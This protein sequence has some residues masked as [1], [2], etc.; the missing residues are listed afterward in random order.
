[1]GVESALNVGTSESGSFRERREK[2]FGALVAEARAL[3]D[4][5]RRGATD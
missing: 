1:M 5:L 2:E 3:H 4:R